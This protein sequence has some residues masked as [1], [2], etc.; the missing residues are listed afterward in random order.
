[1]NGLVFGTGMDTYFGL[2]AKLVEESETGSHFQQAV[3][4]IGYYLIVLAVSPG[5]ISYHSSCY[6]PGNLLQIIRLWQLQS[7]SLDFS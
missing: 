7:P 2:T 4:K 1:M 3:M 6:P 5:D